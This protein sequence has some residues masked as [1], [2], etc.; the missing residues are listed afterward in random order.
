MDD[1]IEAVCDLL[2]GAAY[3]DKHLH[4]NEKQAVE[5]YLKELM[6]EAALTRELKERIDNFSPDKFKLLDVVAVFVGDAKAERMKL[7]DIVAAIHA[8]DEEYDLDEDEFLL[9][10]AQG[11][12]LTEEDVK[13]HALDYE[14]ETLKE[15]L[16][17]VRPTP[18]P[19]PK[20]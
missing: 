18:P 19:I 12:E 3:A 6:P 16:K 9:N 8:A 13:E 15:H 14:V 11:L 5:Q 20:S 1:R 4:E 2:M 7:L 17:I 10:V